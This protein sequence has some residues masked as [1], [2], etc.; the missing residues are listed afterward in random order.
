MH[1]IFGY[2]S[3]GFMFVRLLS[4]TKEYS[5]FLF[6][7]RGVGKS[8]LISHLFDLKNNL[9]INLLDLQEEDLFSRNPNRLIDLVKAM[10]ESSK[11]VIIDEIQK[12]PRLL[13]IVHL[14]IEDKKCHKF[15]ILTGSSARKLKAGGANLLA[16][17]AFVYNLYPFSYLELGKVFDLQDALAFGMLPRIFAFNTADAKQRFLQ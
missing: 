3:G 1:D 4:L 5:V 14:L 8:T 10:S 9:Y 6:G 17:R 15:F 7:A 16:G 12:I 13:D 11:Y 2:M